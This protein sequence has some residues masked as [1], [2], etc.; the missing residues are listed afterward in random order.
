ML[1]SLSNAGYERHVQAIQAALKVLAERA[2][3]A[4]ACIM[5]E[6]QAAATG[7]ERYGLL[8]KATCQALSSG[9][10]P[11]ELHSSAMAIDEA[12]QALFTP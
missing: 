5:S 11:E 10:I 9:L 12:V 2:P 4:Y 7:L 3:A 1:S 8:R 6:A